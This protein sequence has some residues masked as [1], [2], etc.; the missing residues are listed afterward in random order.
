MSCKIP[1]SDLFRWTLWVATACGWALVS[2]FASEQAAINYVQS[3]HVA[4]AYVLAP[5]YTNL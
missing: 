5:E 1:K 2:E 3:R 4:E